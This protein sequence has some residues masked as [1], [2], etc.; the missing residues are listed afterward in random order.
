VNL[1][2]K[3]KT[4]AI[5]ERRK[6]NNYFSLGPGAADEQK[7]LWNAASSTNRRQAK[8]GG[9]HTRLHLMMLQFSVSLLLK[10]RVSDPT[11]AKL[12]Y[13]WALSK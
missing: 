3:K 5:G 8:L 9:G 12:K 1:P 10:F 11:I 6:W 4:K 13:F 2:R 7:E